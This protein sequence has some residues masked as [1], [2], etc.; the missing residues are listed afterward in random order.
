MSNSSEQRA[1]CPN[2]NPASVSRPTHRQP[3]RRLIVMKHNHVMAATPAVKGANVRTIGI[4]RA[5]TSALAQ[6]FS[7]KACAASNPLRLKKREFSHAN[8]RAGDEHPEPVIRVVA[9]STAA[10]SSTAHSVAISMLPMAASAPAAN[11]RSP[12]R[13]GVTTKPVSQKDDQEQ[14]RVNPDAMLRHQFREVLVNVQDEVDQEIDDVHARS[15]GVP[16]RPFLLKRRSRKSKDADPDRVS[17]SAQLGSRA[18]VLRENVQMST[19]FACFR[20]IAG[21]HR[22]RRIPRNL[23]LFADNSHRDA[24]GVELKRGVLHVELPIRVIFVCQFFPLP[25]AGGENG[26][27][28]TCR[29]RR[30]SA[31]AGR[32]AVSSAANTPQISPNAPRAP[33]QKRTFR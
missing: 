9:P 28:E 2:Q 7:K 6:C 12:G 21:Q 27:G 26:G 19:S 22:A 17:A 11:S 3:P 24:G 25:P 30:R 15:P 23:N 18:R 1:T 13:K 10:A 5:S 29:A 14:D 33:A 16:V 20:R 8:T 4:N 32:V 31:K